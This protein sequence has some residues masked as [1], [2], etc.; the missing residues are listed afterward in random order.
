MRSALAVVLLL[1]ACG[2]SEGE[3]K[4]EFRSYVAGANSCSAAAECAIATTDCPLG[5]YHAVRAERK[6]DVEKKG[7]EL[8]E[9]YERGGVSCDY[10][11]APPGDLV[12][13]A[14]RC[15]FAAASGLADAGA[16]TD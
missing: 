2:A 8:V 1:T 4:E 9:R 14:S 15:A 13:Q 3:V 16:G 12:C 6:A 5:C 7:R 11:C 10:K